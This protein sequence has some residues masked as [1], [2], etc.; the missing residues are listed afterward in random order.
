MSTD[1]K[2]WQTDAGPIQTKQVQKAV[3]ELLFEH[4]ATRTLSGVKG[5]NENSD[6]VSYELFSSKQRE[7]VTK[8]YNELGERFGWKITRDNYKRILED[9]GSLL[10]QIKANTP[11]KDERRTPEEEAKRVADMAAMQKKSEET[12]SAYQT[13]YNIELAKVKAAYPWAQQH[14]SE[15]AKGAANLKRLLNDRFPGIAFFAKSSSFAGGNDISISWEDGPTT[16]EVDLIAEDFQYGHFD[17]MDD[18]YEYKKSAVGDAF[19]A[20]M[21]AAKYVK[22][23]RSISFRLRI[24]IAGAV[25]K[26]FHIPMPQNVQY[27]NYRMPD[28]R[29]LQEHIDRA[30][31]V[32]IPSGA[33]FDGLDEK[34]VAKFITPATPP[35][36]ATGSE[37]TGKTGI[38]V[39]M[40]D[41]Q[42]GIELWFD[43]NPSPETIARVKTNGWRASKVGGWH[44]YKRVS[45]QAIAF[46]HEIAG[47]TPPQ[48]SAD[49]AGGYV[50]AQEDAQQDAIA[51]EIEA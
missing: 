13:E 49:P 48:Q 33:M 31:K 44:W 34:G 45:P 19:R 18:I 9:C 51:R 4:K 8:A 30:L 23:S 43:A 32:S 7:D 27:W 20:W 39:K 10:A 37:V 3:G 14:G 17:G 25:C 12:Q 6:F 1:Q 2:R 40:N 24:D 38:R 36:A 22:G 41:A 46:A 42:G 26:T 50:Q 5:A 29:T 11:V 15:H 35:Q 16:A 21:G 28:D 47:T